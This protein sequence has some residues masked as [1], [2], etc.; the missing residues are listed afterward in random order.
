[1]DGLLS[2]VTP[3]WNADP[4]QLQV[5][6]DSVL[7]QDGNPPFEWLIHDN[8]STDPGTRAVLAA[9]AA[10][11]RVKLVRAER[12]LGI[13]GGLR[14]GLERAT[15]RYVLPIDHDDYLYPDALRVV[16]W[17]L[18]EHDYPA[19]LY[20]DEDKLYGTR[21][22]QPYFKPDWDPVLFLNAAYIAHQCAFERERGLLLG[23]WSDPIYEGCHD[24]DGFMRFWQAGYRPAH[25]PEV[26]YGWRIH[27]GST[28]GN[29]GAKRY[30]YDSQRALLERFV[31]AQAHPERYAVEPSP[32]FPGTPN[33]HIRREPI[34]P[35]PIV[36]IVLGSLADARSRQDMR[37]PAPPWQGIERGAP[38]ESLRAVAEDAARDGALMRLLSDCIEPVAP[39]DDASMLWESTGL[40]EL[41]PDT[42]MVGGRIVDAH[43]RVLRSGGYFGYGAGWDSPDDG[44]DLADPGYQAQAWQ[45]HS[46]SVV[47]SDLAVLDPALLIATLDAHRDVAIS[48]AALGAWCGAQARRL[49][50][51]VIYTPFLTGRLIGADAPPVG[52][53]EHAAF[54]TRHGDLMPD[55]ALWSPRHP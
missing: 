33:W 28:S 43:G 46:V 27:A 15:G 30:V 9:L 24:W 50:R 18:A 23:L 10:D 26:L 31:A 39:T 14:A 41:F 54:R 38:I 35:R 32:F 7:R 48:I 2:L 29:I 5:L 44:H 22:C 12:N 36:T 1:M 49:G 45:Q 19:L 52:A 13:I 51:R 20:T 4:A 3:V 42:A 8:A 16:A 25:V 37:H 21:H 40:F 17:H 53:A 11:P 55:R 34:A 47:P 6:A